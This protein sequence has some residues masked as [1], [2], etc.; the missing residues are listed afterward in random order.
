VTLGTYVVESIGAG[1]GIVVL[2]AAFLIILF[3]ASWMS[4]GSH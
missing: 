4:S 3:F 1:P 2:I